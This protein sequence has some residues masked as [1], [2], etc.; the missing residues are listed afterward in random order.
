MDTGC[1][2]GANEG[3]SEQR[4]NEDEEAHEMDTFLPRGDS[5]EPANK[6]N[7]VD[8]E[9]DMESAISRTVVNF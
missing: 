5:E 8:E 4:S 1:S 7:S 6:T 2:L 3:N 9:E